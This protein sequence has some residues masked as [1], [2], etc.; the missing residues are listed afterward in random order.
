VTASL[1]KGWGANGGA[2]PQTDTAATLQLLMGLLALSAAA[3]VS[4]IGRRVA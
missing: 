2:I 1:P 3:F 4:V